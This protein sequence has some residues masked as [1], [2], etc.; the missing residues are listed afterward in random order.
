MLSGALP[1]ENRN[2]FLLCSRWLPRRYA[3]RPGMPGHLWS[4]SVCRRQDVRRCW[5]GGAFAVSRKHGKSRRL[6]TGGYG[7]GICGHR[8]HTADFGHY[9]LRD[10]QGLL[11]HRPADDLQY[12]WFFI[13]QKVQPEPIYEALAHQE[14]V[15]L[16]THGKRGSTSGLNAADIMALR[17]LLERVGS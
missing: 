7:Y 17:R 10:D 8:S 16:P 11:H 3:I 13:S 9:D 12:D 1:A 14:G 15:H 2:P 6:C 5:R 4:E